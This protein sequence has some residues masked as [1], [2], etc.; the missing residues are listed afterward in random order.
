MINIITGAA[1]FIGSALTCKLLDIGHK[2]IGIDNH[3]NYYS[4]N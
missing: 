1:G 3:N 2:V 4:Q